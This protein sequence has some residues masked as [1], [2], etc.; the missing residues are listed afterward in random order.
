MSEIIN[1]QPEMG[2]RGVAIQGLGSFATE[3]ICCLSRDPR[4]NTNLDLEKLLDCAAKWRE[5][6]VLAYGFTYVI[7]TQFVQPL[8]RQGITL[9]IPNVRVLH[10]GGGETFGRETAPKESLPPRLAPVFCPS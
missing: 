9:D 6:E 2:A 8:Q 1:T 5:T 7:W 3:V 10:S 4:G